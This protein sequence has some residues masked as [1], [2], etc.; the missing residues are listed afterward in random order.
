LEGLL[1]RHPSED[2]Y[3]LDGLYGL[4]WAAYLPRET[5]KEPIWYLALGGL[6]FTNSIWDLK[7]E[8]D[9]FSFESTMVSQ[10]GGGISMA[11]D[12]TV[13]ASGEVSGEV[14]IGHM[15]AAADPD[16]EQA[17]K[18][19]FKGHRIQKTARAIGY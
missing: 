1:S 2:G 14:T 12:G 19:P 17:V 16:N 8:G 11:V 13:S 5:D 18:M 10:G 4:P 15:E 3:R 7:W 9:H 6:M